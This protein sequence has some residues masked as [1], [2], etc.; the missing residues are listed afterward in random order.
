M[1]LYKDKYAIGIYKEK[2]N[3][4]QVILNRENVQLIGRH[5]FYCKLF[6]IRGSHITEAI[7]PTNFNYIDYYKDTINVSCYQLI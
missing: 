5:E 7:T 2:H 3:K 6:F 1:K 4:K